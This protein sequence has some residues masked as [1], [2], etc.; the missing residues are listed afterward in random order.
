MADT[1]NQRVEINAED[2]EAK[3]QKLGETGE[4]AFKRIKDATGAAGSQ[5]GRKA[6]PGDARPRLHAHNPSGVCAS[7]GCNKKC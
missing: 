3:L 6:R 4:Q 1:I 7:E 5:H 2:A